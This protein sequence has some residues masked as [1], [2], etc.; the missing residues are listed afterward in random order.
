MLSYIIL[1][2][3]TAAAA[4]IAAILAVYNRRLRQEAVNLRCWA[5]LFRNAGDP[6]VC[7]GREERIL[8][9]NEAAFRTHFGYTA[10]DLI[11]R[12]WS[13]LFADRQDCER[14]AARILGEE[15]EVAEGTEVG[16]RTE[17]TRREAPATQEGPTRP[18]VSGGSAEVRMRTAQGETFPARLYALDLGSSRRAPHRFR[19][20]IRK[21]RR[22]RRGAEQGEPDTAV[23]IRDI[24][25]QK[26]R[27]RQLRESQ[28]RLEQSYLHSLWLADIGRAILA[29]EAVGDVVHRAIGRMA[30]AFP[31]LRVSYAEIDEAQCA[32]I[33]SSAGPR[34]RDSEARDG[35]FLS[36]VGTVLDLTRIPRIHERLQSGEPV[37][38]PDA[39]AR[40]EFSH[41]RGDLERVGIRAVLVAPVRTQERAVGLLA[42]DAETR[43]SWSDDESDVLREVGDFLGIALTH[44]EMQGRIGQ[45]LREKKSLLQEIHHRVKNNLSVVASLLSLQADDIDSV[46]DA[47]QAFISSRNRIFSMA[48][49]HEA[50]Y[51][52][53][54]LSLVDMDDYLERM[55][56]QLLQGYG[57]ADRV[58]IQRDAGQVRLPIDIAVPCGIIINEL[59]SNALRHGFPEPPG[60]PADGEDVADMEDVS[61]VENGSAPKDGSKVDG[62]IGTITARMRCGPPGLCKP[63]EPHTPERTLDGPP[64]RTPAQE[65]GAQEPR[66]PDRRTDPGQEI[67]LTVEDSGGAMARELELA[68][69][70]RKLPTLGL[71]LVQILTEQL[72]GRLEI[73]AGK[74]TTVQVRFPL[75][76]GEGAGAG[77]SGDRDPGTE[78]NGA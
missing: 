75:S 54:E 9:V 78:H 48:L 23:I 38:I 49:V 26:R 55:I 67:L 29:G 52:S 50:L 3:L 20:G 66:L 27:D 5:E 6:I 60:P 57:K 74:K 53:G 17:E 39:P 16:K 4:A 46:D 24:T 56:P 37:A 47:R 61:A 69:A 43:R 28:E 35:E 18:G 41:L 32:R 68:Q 72:E 34:G 8:R 59:I 1:A 62:G 40:P 30:D 65:H 76:K 25:E 14:C 31:G 11:G 63:E 33:E 45:E 36:I 73:T 64:D 58:R 77:H 2:F 19:A 21:A 70:R 42:L 44:A 51:Q 15:T 22:S 7:L 12:H 71:H 13:L 10:G